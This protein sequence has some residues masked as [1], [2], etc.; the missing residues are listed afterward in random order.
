MYTYIYAHIYI[1]YI[2]HSEVC[3][4]VACRQNPNICWLSALTTI[5]NSL[6]AFQHIA[7]RLSHT[8]KR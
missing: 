6:T 5:T 4:C 8:G 3:V 7:M 1:L 2:Y